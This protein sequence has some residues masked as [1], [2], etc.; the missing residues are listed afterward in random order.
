MLEDN[1][2][3]EREKR[4]TAEFIETLKTLSEIERAEVRGYIKGISS[5]RFYTK[6]LHNVEERIST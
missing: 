6:K 4:E 2:Q 5:M 3:V 1:L